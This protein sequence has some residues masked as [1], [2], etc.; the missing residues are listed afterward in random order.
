MVL[1]SINGTCVD[2][3]ST[4]VRI[5]KAFHLGDYPIASGARKE[6]N[7]CV[8]QCGPRALDPRNAT[9]DISTPLGGVRVEKHVDHAAVWAQSGKMEA[10]VV[11]ESLHHHEIL[12]PRWAR[13]VDFNAYPAA[14]YIV[15]RRSLRWRVHSR[16][17]LQILRLLSPTARHQHQTHRYRCAQSHTHSVVRVRRDTRPA[18]P[19]ARPSRVRAGGGSG[20]GYFGAIA[21]NTRAMRS[22]GG[23]LPVSCRNCFGAASARA[24][25]SAAVA[26]AGMEPSV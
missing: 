21:A 16:E 26:G 11:L 6:R 22:P 8:V 9:L 24:T 15:R 3:P 14:G 23:S 13:E 5:S 7:C 10:C 17:R 2:A 12:Q 25:R 19:K 4:A 20:W 1:G 18:T